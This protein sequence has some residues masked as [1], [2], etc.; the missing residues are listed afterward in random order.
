MEVYDRI[1]PVVG[2]RDG[3]LR[4]I[5]DPVAPKQLA[6]RQAD[7]IRRVHNEVVASALAYRQT[8]DL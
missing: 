5:I 4:V 6:P 3:D 8:A 1:I 2:Q 7:L